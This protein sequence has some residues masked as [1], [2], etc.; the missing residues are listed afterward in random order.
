MNL[1][2]VIAAIANTGSLLTGLTPVTK[3]ADHTFTA[4]DIGCEFAHTDSS[5]YT[6]TIDT[7]ANAP[8]AAGQKIAGYCSSTGTLTIAAPSGGS[9]IRLDG[10][11]GTGNRTVHA[12]SY[13]VLHKLD[14][15]NA[16]GISG[17]A[18]S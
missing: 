1:E 7:Y 11:A 10:T 18:L 2:Q 8:I 5:G 6:W 4:A 13:F 16:W 3:N 12:A 17:T 14:N 15:A 9:L